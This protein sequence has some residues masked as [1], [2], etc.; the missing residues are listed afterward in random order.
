LCQLVSSLGIQT[1]CLENLTFDPVKPLTVK[2]MPNLYLY[3]PYIKNDF[4]TFSGSGTGSCQ[5]SFLGVPWVSFM[6]VRPLYR[7]LLSRQAG[8]PWQTKKRP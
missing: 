1:D 4:L 6:A 8:T 2:D 7:S 3:I 5:K